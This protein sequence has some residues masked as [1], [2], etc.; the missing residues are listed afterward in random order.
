MITYSFA[1]KDGRNFA[2]QV[3][4]RRAHGTIAEAASRPAWTRLE[5][6]QC[7][8]CPLGAST[9]PCCPVA[10]DTEE[11]ALKFRDVPSYERVCV[12]VETPERTYS[13][14]CDAQTGL[15]SLLGLVMASSA[16]PILGQLEGLA[17]Y[18]LPFASLEET[19]FRTTG[20]YLLRQYFLFKGGGTPDLE[21]RGLHD[22]YAELNIV[23]RCFQ[24]RLAHA[25]SQDAN[26]NAVG[27]LL[28]LAMGVSLSLED[29]LEELR[30][31]FG[32]QT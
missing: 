2:F 9:H 19:V 7:A 12:T 32:A 17:R 1:L 26:L 24:S 18:H 29:Q 21:L 20:A 3:D 13:K 8:N 27:S 15:R 28:Y 22:L 16:C 23:N 25:S 5:F 11:I 4:P 10:V 31:G 14:E 30:R 6:H